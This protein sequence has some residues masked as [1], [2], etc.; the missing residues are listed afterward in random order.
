M[1]KGPSFLP[2]TTTRVQELPNSAFSESRESKDDVDFM[3]HHL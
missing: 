2:N 3:T 1:G